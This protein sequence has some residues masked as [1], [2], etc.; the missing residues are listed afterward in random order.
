MSIGCAIVASDTK[1]LHEAIRH[2]ETGVLVDF[3]DAP[4]LTKALCELLD[5]AT[6][7]AR[8][9]AAARTFAQTHYDLKTVCLPQ[10][11]A[12]IEALAVNH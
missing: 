12:W 4:A 11:L 3:F 9:G 7:R 10:Q 5:D 2:D 8:L 1:P 6:R